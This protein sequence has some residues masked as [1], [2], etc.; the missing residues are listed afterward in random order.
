MF[1]TTNSNTAYRFAGTVVAITGAAA[2]IGRTT[3]ELFAQAGA[4]VALLDISPAVFEVASALGP[5]HQGWSVDVSAADSVA[6]VAKEVIARFGRVDVLVN[7][8]GI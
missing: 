7:N 3:A 4:S 2:G 8:A 5:T 6:Q 1:V